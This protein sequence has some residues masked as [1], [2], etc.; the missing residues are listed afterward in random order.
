MHRN[1]LSEA[2]STLQAR[3]QA[4]V[5]THRYSLLLSTDPHLLFR[6]TGVPT[7]LLLSLTVIKELKDAGVMIREWAAQGVRI[8]MS[9]STLPPRFAS[10]ISPVEHIPF[11]QASK[12]PITLV[13]ATYRTHFLNELLEE[14]V[15]SRDHIVL[16]DHY[17]SHTRHRETRGRMLAYVADTIFL[18]W[19]LGNLVH[20]TN[21][22]AELPTWKHQ[23]KPQVIL[24]L[25]R[26][27]LFNKHIHAVPKEKEEKEEDDDDDDDDDDDEGENQKRE[28]TRRRK[29]FPTNLIFYAFG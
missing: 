1:L 12:C 5:N 7:G 22:F 17:Q 4:L 13:V 8:F 10:L 15:R 2:G 18:E 21:R 3:V 27:E 6:F 26:Q 20:Y 29:M 23:K 9:Q 25:H 24:R 16:L 11:R 19:A 28:N 14:F